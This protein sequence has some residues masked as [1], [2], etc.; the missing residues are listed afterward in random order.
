MMTSIIDEICELYEA[1]DL[2]AAVDLA[3][4]RLQRMRDDGRAW[5]LMG[6]IQYSRGRYRVSVSALE[7]ASLLVPLR[8]AARVCLGHGYGRVGRTQ[9][10]RDLL[11]ALI[12]DT[13]LPVPLLLQVA[14]G[15]DFIDQPQLSLRAA[16]TACEREPE[17]AQSYY[18]LGYYSARCGSPPVVTESL[19]RKAISLD[20]GNVS[21][22]VGLA[23]LLLKLG[24]D[25]EALELVADFNNTQIEQITCQC[26]LRRVTALFEDARDYR[27]VILCRQQ[28]LILECRGESGTCH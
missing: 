22:R 27:R 3:K 10:S 9:L 8:P 1:G 16:R 19:A 7:R 11:S 6:L 4:A 24:R 12:S 15:L 17:M 26:C 21:Y 23:S 20:P 18:D 5:E 28:L 25:R 14:A 13:S 2:E